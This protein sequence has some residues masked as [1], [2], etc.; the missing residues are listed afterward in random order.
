MA[1]PGAIAILVRAARNHGSKDYGRLLCRLLLRVFSCSA[2]G[3]VFSSPD[4][5]LWRPVC[6]GEDQ[7]HICALDSLLGDPGIHGD[8]TMRHV[9]MPTH[10][11]QLIMEVGVELLLWQTQD[12]TE[13]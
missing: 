3:P 12:P 6:I 2:P 1:S 13:H 10:S 11:T 7:E 8:N 5:V 4:A 9:T